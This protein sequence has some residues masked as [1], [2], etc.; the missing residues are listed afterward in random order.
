[1]LRQQEIHLNPKANTIN[2]NMSGLKRGLYIVNLMA[3][4]GQYSKVIVKD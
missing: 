3:E 2:V 4:D 1:M